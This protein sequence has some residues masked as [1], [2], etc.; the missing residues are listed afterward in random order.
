[1]SSV[2]DKERKAMFANMNKVDIG[3]SSFQIPT[4]HEIPVF[5]LKDENE[6]TSFAES[7]FEKFEKSELKI[8]K[9]KNL[10]DSA[11]VQKIEEIEKKEF[12]IDELS[13]T[14]NTVQSPNS[15]GHEKFVVLDTFLKDKKYTKTL[16]ISIRK[17]LE[18]Q[19]E[20]LIEQNFG[21]KSST[22]QDKEGEEALIEGRQI[23]VEVKIT[24][25]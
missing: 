22:T 18:D 14:L 19:R 6:I 5:G 1:V 11:K 16:P 13:K 21:K 23:E 20:L 17:K 7:N 12:A 10:S 2:S 4:T 15:S 8:V 3:I 25:G 24:D 9:D